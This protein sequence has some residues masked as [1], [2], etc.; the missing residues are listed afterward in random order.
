LNWVKAHA[1][2]TYFLLAF[3]GTWFTLLPVV[4]G[5]DGLGLF[6]F[7]V[8]TMPFAIL[9][10]FLGPTLA[11]LVTTAFVDGKAGVRRLFQRY[12]IWRVGIRWYLTV[13]LGPIVLLVLGATLFFGNTPLT[14]LL[15]RW[16]LFFTA[17]LANLPMVLLLGGPLGEEPGWRGFALPRLQQRYGALW[18]SLILGVLHGLWHLPLFFIAEAYAPFTWSGLLLFVLGVLFNAI[19]WTWV[20]N[21]TR[22]SLLMVTLLHAAVNASG[23]FVQPLLPTSAQVDWIP[24]VAY[25][26][27][28]LLI[29]V[30]TKG[31]LAYRQADDAAA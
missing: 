12:Q 21:Q 1:L 14:A 7:R 28:A 5:Q 30:L 16:P 22:G 26:G 10:P 4:L 17:Y 8:P 9:M 31:A 25:G 2:T 19:I 13:L 20:F 27:C 15:Q 6:A 11:A 29:I 18:G 23:G 3:A 24:L